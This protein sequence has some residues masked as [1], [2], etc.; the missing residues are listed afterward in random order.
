MP[1]TNTSLSPTSG[2]QG[3]RLPNGNARV[4]W[5]HRLQPSAAES[6]RA[7]ALLHGR[8]DQQPPLVSAAS[9]QRVLR[10]VGRGAHGASSCEY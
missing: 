8:G 6:L 3:S 4:A 5:R 1:T 2:L 7:C 9:Q 10:F